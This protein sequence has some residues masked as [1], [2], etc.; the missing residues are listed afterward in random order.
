MPQ[1]KQL[2]LSL[3]ILTL[4]PGT[5]STAATDNLTASQLYQKGYFSKALRLAQKDE[6]HSPLEQLI[7]SLCQIYDKRNQNISSGLAGLRTIYLDQTIKANA[8]L[9]WAEA[10]LSYARIIQV[11]QTRKRYPEYEQVDISKVYRIIIATVPQDTR[12]CTATIYL[13]EGYLSS[14][15]LIEQEKGFAF[16][17]NFIANYTGDPANLTP[18]HI[19]LDGYYINLKKDYASSFKH[20]RTAYETGINKEILA[21]VTLFRLGR[22]CDVKLNRKKQAKVY[23]KEFL[24]LFPNDQR[25]SVARSY[26]AE[27][28]GE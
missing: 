28:K 22:I 20:L 2:T 3:L 11:L 18:L 16:I 5:P 21:R 8:S 12:A 4:L 1:L 24:R 9:I 7:I 19:Y 26:L 10:A 6:P 14:N 17:E 23:Y 25:A 27:L 15:D 13:T